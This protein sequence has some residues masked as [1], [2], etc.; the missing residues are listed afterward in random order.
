MVNFWTREKYHEIKWKKVYWKD[1]CPFCTNIK[2]QEWHIIWKW[3]YWFLIHNLYPY[4]WNNKHLMA[5][6]YTHKKYYLELSDEEIL[7]LKNV[8]IFIKDFFEKK[9]IFLV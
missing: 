4:S 8:N 5:V 9:T 3:K 2:E 7:D 1:N 6:P